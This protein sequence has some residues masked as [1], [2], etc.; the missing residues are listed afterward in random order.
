ARRA[1]L[2]RYYASSP[3]SIVP[4]CIIGYVGAS[5]P[6][7]W[8]L[9][10]GSNGTPDL[11]DRFIE[12]STSN[13]AGQSYG[14]NLVSASGEV[15]AGGGHGHSGDLIGFRTGYGHAYHSD[16][17]Q[18]RHEYTLSTH[19]EPPYFAMRFIQYTGAV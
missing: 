12:L 4:G 6:A 18:H 13:N 17:V 11:R 10:D 8:Y 9:C 3:T 2:A 7:G 19:H 5:L 1:R 16:I 15:S 14:N